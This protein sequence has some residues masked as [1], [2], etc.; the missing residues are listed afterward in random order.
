MAPPSSQAP[1]KASVTPKAVA[2]TTATAVQPAAKKPRQPAAK[3]VLP[4][5]T[6]RHTVDAAEVIPQ[7][8]PW[9]SHFVRD[10]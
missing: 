10:A 2:P 6:E 4:S 3:P 1:A 7:I 5:G 8:A 9:V